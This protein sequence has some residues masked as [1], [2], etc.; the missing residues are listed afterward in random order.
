MPRVPFDSLPDSARVWVF[1]SERP[2]S[3]REAENML[4]QADGFLD[5]WN[6]HGHPLTCARQWTGDRFLT[7]G[8]DQT[9]AGA[10]GCSID[11]LFRLL[12]VT[13]GELGTRLVGGGL[14]FYRDRDGDIHAATRDE[15][16][17]LAS[18]GK[19]DDN[20]HV[21]DTTV[22]RAGDWRERFETEL[23]TSWHADIIQ[24]Q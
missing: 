10:S 7:V 5:S 23:S 19:V 20:T 15:F 6:A 9:T 4:A 17:A 18:S 14:V 21:F 13:E 24:S 16:A 22:Q 8:V 1:G 11:G 12:R 3:T 2:L